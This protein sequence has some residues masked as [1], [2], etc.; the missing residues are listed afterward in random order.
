VKDRKSNKDESS[1]KVSKDSSVEKR[2]LDSK[3]VHGNGEYS[4]EYGSSSKRRRESGGGG[5]DRW[6]GGDEGSK[7]SKAIGDSKSSR[8]RDGSVGLHGDGEEAKRSSGKHRDSSSSGRKENVEKEKE[9]DRKL[10]EGRIEESVN[11]QEQR[12]SKLVLEN[13]GMNHDY[14][15][16]F[17]CVC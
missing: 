1:V 12:S 9:K 8:R 10:K 17:I 5:G 14:F 16:S 11:D 4:D 15:N 7:K 3:E 6:N 13:N 2:R